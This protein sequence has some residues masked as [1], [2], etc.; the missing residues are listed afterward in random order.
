MRD[1]FVPDVERIFLMLP[2][3]L[4]T[5]IG[6]RGAEVRLLFFARLVHRSKC[7]ISCNK[8]CGGM[9]NKRFCPFGGSAEKTQEILLLLIGKF[10]RFEGFQEFH[11]ACPSVGS[12]SESMT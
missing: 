7:G 5:K 10:L 6:N 1:E 3:F 2:D 9:T 8:P 4:S 11:S 12:R